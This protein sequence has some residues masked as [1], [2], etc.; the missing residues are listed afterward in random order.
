MDHDHRQL[1]DLAADDRLRWLGS[2]LADEPRWDRRMYLRLAAWAVTTVGALVF[3]MQT[4]HWSQG[5]RHEQLAAADL[6]RQS[7]QLQQ[8]AHDSQVQNRRLVAAIDTLNGDR[9]R[10]YARVTVLEQGLDSVTGTVAR[11]SEK[12]SQSPPPSL[13]LSSAAVAL[14]L[15]PPAISA[16]P[17]TT[18]H[19]GEPAAAP[20]ADTDA[21][22]PRPARAPNGQLAADPHTPLTSATV[23]G[24]PDPAASRLIENGGAPPVS[25]EHHDRLAGKLQDKLPEKLVEKPA[26]QQ[27]PQPD[28]SKDTAADAKAADA[29]VQIASNPP[30]SQD[31]AAASIG[32]TAQAAPEITVQHTEFGVDLGGANSLDGLRALWRSLAKTHSTSA[33]VAPLRPIVVIRERSNG[34]GMQLRLVAGPLNDAAAA[35][36]ICAA[37]TENGRSCETSVFDGQRL[38]LKA[39][40]EPVASP[41]PVVP[42]RPTTPRS[43]PQH[44]HTSQR[45][46]KREDRVPAEPPA[47]PPPATTQSTAPASPAAPSSSSSIVPEF[48]RAH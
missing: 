11:Q 34:L 42:V 47:Q 41:T 2:F 31:G 27:P 29:K 8:A 5:G 22:S 4:V 44:R 20:L 9:D 10:L 21:S 18:A 17:V 43:A 3:A 6:A 13:V 37:L 35:A 14:A 39:E 48:L 28:A 36:R 23:Y 19:V 12:Q 45:M 30:A 1:A 26:T 7:Q 32:A 38:A 33:L 25:T 16:P 24:P 46:V 40:A 15:P